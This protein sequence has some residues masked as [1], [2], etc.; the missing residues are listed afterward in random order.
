[1]FKMLE[2]QD[3]EDLEGNLMIIS[4]IAVN[5][6]EFGNVSKLKEIL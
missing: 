4:N 6:N 2:Y 3:K 1:M 5:L